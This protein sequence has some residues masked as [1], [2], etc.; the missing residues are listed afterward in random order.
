MKLT[1]V[2]RLKSELERLRRRYASVCGWA[3]VSVK[4][5]NAMLD[6]QRTYCIPCDIYYD[7]NDCPNEHNVK[8]NDLDSAERAGSEE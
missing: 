7:G 5:A 8:G 2:A 1:K 3:G 6:V 4:V